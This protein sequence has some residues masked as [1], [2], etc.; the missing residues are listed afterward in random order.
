MKIIESGGHANMYDDDEEVEENE[1][2]KQR[3]AQRIQSIHRG[4]KGRQRAQ[5]KRGEKES[6]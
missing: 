6:I 5:K 4:K 2:E 1:V 3:A